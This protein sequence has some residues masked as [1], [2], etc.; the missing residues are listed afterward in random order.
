MSDVYARVHND[1]IL[2]ANKR[3]MSSRGLEDCYVDN[4]Y[5]YLRHMK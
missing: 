1:V 2:I 4:S 3:M 5:M